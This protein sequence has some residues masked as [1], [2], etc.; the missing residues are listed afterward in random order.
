MSEGNPYKESG[1]SKLGVLF[2]KGIFDELRDKSVLDFGC[3]DGENCIELAER[4]VRRIVGLDIQESRLAQA[5]EE[6]ARRGVIHKC[7]FVDQCARRFDVVLSTD[8]FEHFAD[9]AASLD[10]MQGLLSENGYI[11]IEFGSTWYHPYGGHLFSVFPWAH[12][13]FTECALIRW[14]SD[15]K[16]DGARRFGEVAGG[17]NQM[18][19]RRWERLVRDS[20]LEFKTYELV[21]IRA[22]RVF[23]NRLTRE[24]TTSFIR[25]RLQTKKAHRPEE[26]RRQGS[27]VDAARQTTPA[28][29]VIGARATNPDP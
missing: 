11:L 28:Q 9:P 24:F 20:A 4:G 12:L 7:E 18:T 3:G 15:F 26:R 21:P 25:A 13:V 6:A 29:H 22:A 27:P 17:L 10:R 14:R 16:T 19:L 2:G 8:A 1:L 23:H 5:R